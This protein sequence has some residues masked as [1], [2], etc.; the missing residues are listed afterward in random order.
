MMKRAARAIAVW[1]WRV[2]PRS[3]RR[4]LLKSGLYAAASGEPRSALTELLEIDAILSGQIDLA[5]LRYG[6]GVH[7]K[8]RLMAYHDFFVS[9]IRSGERVLDVGCGYGAVADSIA[10]RA[11]AHVVGIDLNPSNIDHAKKR[12]TNPR[13][14][15]VVGEAPRDLPKEPFDVVVLSNVLEHVEQRVRFLAALIERARPQRILIRV[16]MADRHWHVPLRR[17]LGLFHFSDPTHFTEYTRQSFEDEMREAH[18][19]ITH[20]QVNWGEIWAEVTPGA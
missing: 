9:R 3:L 4:S 8:H 11:N 5:S 14:Q 10:T 1:P 7:V 13:L 19:A 18:L 2:L 17:E 12:F 15:F 6:D 16:P 20:F